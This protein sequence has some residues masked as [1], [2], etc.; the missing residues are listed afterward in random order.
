V[1][2]GSRADIDDP[3]GSTHDV[4]VV[5]DDEERVAR[6]LQGVEHV[7]QRLGVRRVQPR[8]RLV[9]N[10]DDPEKPRA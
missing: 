5:L 4:E 10:V 9:E 2:T 7:E 6:A 3:V 8:G 1:L